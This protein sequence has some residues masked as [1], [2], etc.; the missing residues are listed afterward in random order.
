MFETASLTWTIIVPFVPSA[1]VMDGL[2]HT[3]LRPYVTPVSCTGKGHQV[4][5]AVIQ[6]FVYALMRPAMYTRPATSMHVSTDMRASDE[7]TL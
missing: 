2:F 6:S 4:S 3:E 5:A 7:L 1:P